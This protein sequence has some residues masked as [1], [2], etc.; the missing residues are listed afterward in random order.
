MPKKYRFLLYPLLLNSVLLPPLKADRPLVSPGLIEALQQKSPESLKEGIEFQPGGD[1]MQKG[2]L[3]GDSLL[4]DKAANELKGNNLVSQYAEID[5]LRVKGDYQNAN[6]LLDICGKTFFQKPDDP[7]PLP[8]ISGVGM[9]C[10]QILAG[11]YFLDG[12]LKDWGKS[13]DI[14][15]TIYYP[16]IRKF[17]GLEQFSLADSK[18]GKL[19]I[20]PNSV[21]TFSITGIDRQQNI[22]LHYP[23]ISEEGYHNSTWDVPYM[24]ASLN[25]TNFPFF[26][27]TDIAISKLPKALSQSPHVHI[28]GYINRAEN[29]RSQVYDGDLGIVDELKIGNAVLK[30]VPFIFANVDQAVLGL[31]VLQKLGKIRIDKHQFSFGKNIACNCQQ[32]I[33]LGSEL[34]GDYQMLKYPVKWREK[35]EMVTISL[36]QTSLDDVSIIISQHNFTP[37]EEKQSREITTNLPNT[38]SK[39]ESIYQ[40]EVNLI[41]DGIN[42]GKTKELFKKDSVHRPFRS[43]GVS[44]LEKADLYLDFIN[45]KACLKPN[46]SDEQPIPQ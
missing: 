46:N 21:P 31:M 5:K 2:L 40:K 24:M 11:N 8:P 29:G 33:H 22:P 34:G 14:I 4:I 37:E 26:I 23:K 44:I 42:Y 7:D 10:Q 30:N 17:A 28:I 20:A 36:S 35:T 12:N 25:G 41:I 32:D 43:M 27:G 9:V 3:E 39:E 16:A 18:I 6:K 15:N 45:H 13:L 38:K 19:S 1:E